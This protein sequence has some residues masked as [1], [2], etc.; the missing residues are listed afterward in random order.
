VD[1]RV[2]AHRITGTV[3]PNRAG[4]THAVQVHFAGWFR[5]MTNRGG[6]AAAT[7]TGWGGPLRIASIGLV[8]TFSDR[9]G[10]PRLRLT[11]NLLLYGDHQP[12]ERA[13]ACAAA[14]RRVSV[15]R[16]SR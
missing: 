16:E 2:A 10:F 15:H 1:L 11:E 14:H 4:K 13:W 3:G 12:G 9:R 8:R 5:P 7:I 6:A